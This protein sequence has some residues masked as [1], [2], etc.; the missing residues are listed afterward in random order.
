MNIHQIKSKKKR[1]SKN[2]EKLYVLMVVQLRSD[3][4]V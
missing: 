3:S 1:K 2:E 4:A